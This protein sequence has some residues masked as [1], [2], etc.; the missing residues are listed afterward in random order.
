MWKRVPHL[1]QQH[2]TPRKGLTNQ[3]TLLI[4]KEKIMIVM[5]FYRET[6]NENYTT[7]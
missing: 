7:Y 3:V 1:M 4:T 5:T 6:E 2:S